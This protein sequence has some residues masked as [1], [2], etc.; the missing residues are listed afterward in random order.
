VEPKKIVAENFCNKIEKL[1]LT[2]DLKAGVGI[3]N[4]CGG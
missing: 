2:P 4:L 1:D 3:F